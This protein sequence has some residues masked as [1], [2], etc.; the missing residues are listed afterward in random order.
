MADAYQ[1]LSTALA[2][3]P[4]AL[5]GLSLDARGEWTAQTYAGVELRLGQGAPDEHV[6]VL[7]GSASRA[8]STRWREVAYVDLRYTNGFSVGWKDQAA[9]ELS[10]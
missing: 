2:A 9:E 7:T 10:Q 5:S 4:L 8:L 3:T 6:A 1:R